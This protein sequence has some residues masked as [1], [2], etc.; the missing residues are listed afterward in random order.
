MDFVGVHYFQV[1]VVEHPAGRHLGICMKSPKESLGMIQSLS[2]IP[3]AKLLTDLFSLRK[4]PELKAQD[5]KR[6][7]EP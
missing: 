7:A 6:R 2:L 1:E 4:A 5:R 3:S